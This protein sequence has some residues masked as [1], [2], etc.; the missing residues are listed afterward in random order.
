MTEYVSK[1]WIN[2]NIVT[3]TKLAITARPLGNTQTYSRKNKIGIKS[4]SEKTKSEDN[5]RK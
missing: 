3:R 4:Q 5:V 1:Q 2:E